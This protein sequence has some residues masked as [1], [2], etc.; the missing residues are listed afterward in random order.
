MSEGSSL[1]KSDDRPTI[2][3]GR[4]TDSGVI[5]GREEAEEAYE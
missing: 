2:L 1:L 3:R 5:L 4:I